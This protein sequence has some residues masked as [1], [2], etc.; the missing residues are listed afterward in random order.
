MTALGDALEAE[1][2]ALYVYG[3]LGSRAT[4]VQAQR[5]EAAYEA[6][7]S[8]RDELLVLARR[9]GVS[10]PPGDVYPTPSGLDSPTGIQA[11]AAAVE[12]SCLGVY[13]ALVAAGSGELR[14]FAA[15]ALSDCAAQAV[16]FKAAPTPLPGLK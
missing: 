15:Q 8:R 11:A 2:A 16:A 5:L 4:G 7:R 13:A 6:H 14:R 1:Q 9:R 3:V 10:R 12:T